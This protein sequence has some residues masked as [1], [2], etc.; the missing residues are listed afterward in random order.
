MLKVN[1]GSVNEKFTLENSLED[2]FLDSH[3]SKK[4]FFSK[5]E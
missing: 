2:G 3:E 4:S 5:R 1:Y